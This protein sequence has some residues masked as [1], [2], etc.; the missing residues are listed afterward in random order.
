[1]NPI[2]E[3]G[4]M[5]LTDT[6]SGVDY[7]LRPSFSAMSRIGSPREIVETFYELHNNS[8]AELITS[9]CRR[10]TGIS[11]AKRSLYMAVSGN[12][13]DQQW[14]LKYLCG[15]FRSKKV[16]MAAMS[17]IQACCEKD[18]SALTGEL[19]PSKS[20]KWSFVYKKGLMSPAEMVVIAQSLSTHGIIGKAKVRQLQRHENNAATP[21]FNSY[22]Y[23]NAARIHFDMP[24]EQAE[25]LTMT[26]FQLLLNAKYPEQK[27]LTRDEY[28]AVA[29]DYMKKKAARLAKNGG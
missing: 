8:D 5:V 7:F 23:I 13:D 21:E 4:E 20:G 17:F 16:L 1:M 10:L 3:H 14:L 24:R 9:E 28:D 22:E 15:N 6:K 27:G 19:I 18:V 26:E 11:N 29:D 25:K 2:L 12:Q